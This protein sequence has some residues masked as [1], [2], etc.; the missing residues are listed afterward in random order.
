MIPSRER[1]SF[2]TFEWLEIL[3]LRIR[4]LRTASDIEEELRVHAD[5]AM[6]DDVSSG[7]E[8]QQARRSARLRL[9]ST[10]SITQRVADQE[11]I[12]LAESVV[13]DL[14]QGLRALKQSPV[15]SLT[16]ILTLA[17][18]I[19][20]NTAIFSLLYGLYWHP[21]P[22]AQP[23]RLAQIVITMGRESD[24]FQ[25]NTLY[26]LTAEF[27]SRQRSFSEI[28]FWDAAN[29][30]LTDRAGTLRL[31]D[32]EL[33]S[34]N[35]W[36]LLGL[37]PYLGRFIH[38]SDD[39]PG[40][41][42]GG[43][44]VV[45]S[46]D[47]WRERFSADRDI[48]GRHFVIAGAPAV[49][50]GVGPSAFRG[51]YPG[52][53]PKFYL[54]LRFVS[55][56]ATRELV[57]DPQILYGCSAIGRLRGGVTLAASDAEAEWLG[58]RLLR[59]FVPAEIRRQPEF[60]A[61]RLITRS[62]RAGLPSGIEGEYG[63]PLLV[64]QSLVAVVLLLCCINVGGLLMARVY[65]REQEFAVRSAI[66]AGRW[67]MMRQFLTECWVVA[68][69]GSGLGGALA[70]SACP[71]LLRFFRN[72][73]V[74][75]TV[76]VKPD[77]TVFWVTALTAFA[78][79]ILFGTAPAWRAGLSTPASLLTSRKLRARG[80]DIGARALIPLQVGLSLVLVT[81]ATMLCESLIH[82][83]RQPRGFSLDNVTIQTPPFHWLRQKGNEKL[84]VYQRM[85]DRIAISP[86]IRSVAVTWFTPLTGRQPTAL[87]QPSGP[88]AAL[89]VRMPFNTV[90][91]GYFRTMETHIVAG[92][93]FIPSDRDSNFCILNRSAAARLF[94]LQ[95]AVGQTVLTK[96]SYER[97]ALPEC[98]VIGLAQDAAFASLRDASPPT[99]YFP[100]SARVAGDVTNLVFLMNASNKE[101]AAS[102]YRGALHEIAPQIPVVLFATMR[103]QMNAALGSQRLTTFLSGLFA[104]L[105]LFLT[106]L[107]LY[108]LLSSSV[109]QRTG[110]MGIRIAL[111]ASPLAAVGIVL[112]E[113]AGLVSAGVVLGAVG[114][115]FS[116]G[117]VRNMLFGLQE[118]EPAPLAA[119]LLVLLAVTLLATV[120]PALRA[121]SIDPIRALRV[122]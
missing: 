94:P 65:L 93:E 83:E 79:T 29:A 109:V 40:T 91:P 98:R 56:I 81:L 107:G 60:S 30:S 9:G 3:L 113:S 122:D 77:S 19:G 21:L 99:V 13:Q 70:W 44:P 5:M 31:Y 111:G 51:V 2:L 63:G 59:E 46:Y 57:D 61:A 12:T 4:R 34:G 8:P 80:R 68:L 53:E 20:A 117:F 16:A 121:V 119:S 64:M 37:E 116:V 36:D 49:V 14:S 103:E 15:F 45:L 84:D 120:P 66:G 74:F 25:S 47:F 10:V 27:R 114:V 52:I 41:P 32:V 24:K 1:S 6:E 33:T 101:Q 18:G 97:G 35:A 88:A 54:P 43:W 75:E 76:S 104:M 17:A 110:E 72:P 106:A 22:V 85:V 102:A 58:K 112:R 48:I 38:P 95:P 86:G 42:P 69:L 11:W 92:R 28:S 73:T 23:S 50:I 100:I 118:W 55:V 26:R 67:R 115:A 90:G 82:F 96:I 87:F 105:A 7:V 71:Y 62:A 89:S 39:L 78:A 108:G